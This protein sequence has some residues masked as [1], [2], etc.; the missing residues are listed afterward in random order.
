MNIIRFWMQNARSK[1]LPQSMLPAVLALCM[2]SQAE[3]FSVWLGLLAVAG[4]IAGHLSMNLFDDYFD[5]KIKK[6]DFRDSMVRKGFRARIAKCAY[7][8]SGKS[9]LKQTLIACLAFGA[10]AVSMGFL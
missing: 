8:T 7:I 1:S 6:S 2:A 9:D 5:Y 4:V 10:V 3:G